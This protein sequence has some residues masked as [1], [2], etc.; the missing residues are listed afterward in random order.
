MVASVDAFIDA[1]RPTRSPR[2]PGRASTSCRR[3]C[4]P[5]TRRAPGR[6]REHRHRRT[7][8]SPRGCGSSTSS[9]SWPRR[10]T[11]RRPTSRRSLDDPEELGL[12]DYAEGNPEGYL[13][14]STYD[15]GPNE[16]PVDMLARMV[17]RWEQAADGRRPRGAR[18][19]AR[20]HAG[21]ADDD[22]EPGR[23]RGP[24]RRHA[25]GRPGHLQPAREHPATAGT[26][27]C[28]QIDATVNYARDEPAGRHRPRRRST[29]ADS[30]YNTY[31]QPGLPPGPIEAPGDAAISRAQPGRRRLVLLRHGQP[32]DRRDQVRRDYDEF[33]EYKEEL[34]RVLRQPVRPVLSM[35]GRHE[36]RRPG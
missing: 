5:T 19:G 21:R 33:L 29:V 6:P 35:A 17:E 9:T 12:P 27:G 28:L 30:P 34:R 4:R 24:R 26:T 25:E 23:G 32:G 14:P 11:S 36:V 8:R 10:P 22:R 18:R 3:R 15:F 2:H 13:F 1:A 31:K 7:S 16:K 20:L